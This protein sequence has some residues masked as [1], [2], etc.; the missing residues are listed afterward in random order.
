MSLSPFPLGKVEAAVAVIAA[1]GLKIRASGGFNFPG[2]S[3][4]RITG[5]YLFGANGTARSPACATRVRDHA[6][7]PQ[8]AGDARSPTVRQRHDRSEPMLPG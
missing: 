1:P 4:F 5:V 7:S 8:S 6:H 3:V 2:Y